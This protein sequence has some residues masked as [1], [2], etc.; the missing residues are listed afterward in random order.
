MDPITV[1]TTIITLGT[2]IKDL[3]EL[4]EGIRTSIEKVSENR[5]Q[6]RDLTQDIV[7]T[8]YDLASLTRGKEGAFRG[9]ELLA[10]LESLKAEMLNVHSKCLKISP[11]QLPGLQGIPSHLRTWRKRDDLEKKIAR[12]RERVN[13]CL[14]QFNAFSAARTELVAL[15]V[16]NIALRIEQRLILDNLESRVN[17]RRLEGLMAPFM[18]ESEFGQ[19]KL[20]ETAER[21]SV[22]SSFQSLEYQ[23]MSA[24]LHSLINSVKPLLVC[25]DLSLVESW[26]YDTLSFVFV[27]PSQA[28]PSHALSHIL[29]IV[30]A[31]HSRDH[32]S[33][34]DLLM[35][36]INHLPVCFSTAGMH[37]E[38]IVWAHFEIDLHRYMA[39]RGY[40]IGFLPRIADA[41]GDISRAHHHQFELDVAVEFSQQSLALWAEI[42]HLLPEADNRIG[43]LHSMIIH[44]K[45]LL[46]K[47]DNAAMLSAAQDAVSLARPMAKA[48]IESIVSRGTPLTDGERW[49]AYYVCD[50]LFILAEVLFSLHRSLDSYEAFVEGSRTACSL[51]IF[52][53]DPGH[54]GSYIDS[55][56]E[57]ICKVAEDSRLSLSMLA[58]CVDLFHN[59][60]CICPKQSSSGFL[61]ILHAFAYFSKPP[62]S[63]HSTEQIRLFLEPTHHAAPPAVDIATSIPIDSSVL[64]DAMRLFFALARD[65]STIPL[66]QNILVAHFPPAI[67][68]LRLVVQSPVLEDIILS[69]VLPIASA[70]LPRISPA[71]YVALL[72]VLVEGA[73][74]KRVEGAPDTWTF[75]E[76]EM[77]LATYFRRVCNHAAR[78]RVVDEGISIC[79]EVVAYLESQSDAHP[80]AVTWLQEF[81]GFW[82]ILLCDAACFPD[83]ADLV[84]RKIS[85]FP[86]CATLAPDWWYLSL[87]VIKAHI[88]QCVGRHKEALQLVRS[89]VAD[90]IRKFWMEGPT[91][92]LHLYF[93]LPQLAWAWQQ[94][95]RPESALEHAEKAVTAC[96][97]IDLEDADKEE[98][99]CVQIH[100][101]T[102]HSNCLATVGKPSESLE[103]ARKAVSLYT[104]YSE[105]M[106][107]TFI[108]TIRSQELGGNA[109]LA[110]SL[111]LLTADDTEEAL[112]NSRR[113]T[114]LYRELAALAPRHLPTLARSLRHLASVL[115]LLGH[116]DEATAASEEAVDILRKVADP[117]TY[118]LPLFA[119]TLYELAG[120]LAKRG[121]CSGASS[122]IAE[123]AAARV[124]FSSL[125]PEPEWLFMQVVDGDEDVDLNW[126]E[127]DV[128]QYHD[129]VEGVATM[130]CAEADESDDAGDLKSEDTL[131]TTGIV[132]VEEEQTVAAETPESNISPIFVAL[133]DGADQPRFRVKELNDMNNSGTATTGEA[134]KGGTE[135]QGTLT[136]IFS[137]PVEI[138]FS[139]RSTLMDFIWWILLLLLASLLAVMYARIS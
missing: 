115:W 124:R 17:A 127:W 122:A 98:V 97:D 38:V 106:W 57:V 9:P 24:Q 78:L 71:Q 30:V 58:D 6:I 35:T 25:G 7:R 85:R 53:H 83:A 33:L 1:T 23:Y 63:S 28:T 88:L 68:A 49:E 10:A 55:F 70:A 56:L 129:A 19:R 27:E 103:S 8:L 77:Y 40:N 123:A 89:G 31:L 79:Q 133:G 99:L 75:E 95:G 110:L 46:A 82:G 45:N 32:A 66:I 43:Y 20:R 92:N 72:Q 108:F 61:H 34:L 120:Y 102:I 3:I 107:K 116:E 21:I 132:E 67:E 131:G 104:E 76:W 52:D 130:D 135:A 119:D 16:A 125:P 2:F 84:N 60:A 65:N 64:V 114:A 121:D 36:A 105:S 29:Q 54:W 87:C 96:R 4:G 74:C 81:Y 91:F 139:M 50:A 11:K 73:K 26:E 109:F 137:K 47:D 136:N 113:A 126:W 62:D 5:R 100:S 80:R 37:S 90:G 13:K 134:A 39:K 14:L 51:P 86:Q 48:L 93:L 41:L 22:D 94:T 18:L 111:R 118:L 59:L 112:S 42:S 128:G 101:L 44:A 138:R 117:K 15:E 69:W 12:L